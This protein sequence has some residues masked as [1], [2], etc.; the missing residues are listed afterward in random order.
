MRN[1]LLLFFFLIFTFVFG[2]AQHRGFLFSGNI[3]DSA[4]TIIKNAHILNLTSKKGT[5]SNDFGNY[6]IRAD[7]GDTLR[8]SSVQYETIFRVVKSHDLIS[9][10]INIQLK[11]KAYLLKEIVLKQHNLTGV[12]GIDLKKTP[13]DTVGEIVAR[14][15]RQ[16]NSFSLRDIME[17]PVQFNEMH[18]VKPGFARTDPTKL[19]RGAGIVTKLGSQNRKKSNRLQM[20]TKKFSAKKLIQ[21]I[22]ENY[23]LMLK[24]PREHHYAFIDFCRR[25]NLEELYEKNKMLELLKLLEEKSIVFLQKH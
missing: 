23:L 19:F 24:I 14:F 1:H 9:K 20:I 3:K 25:F 6:R 18:L 7:L 15:N 8:I 10:T 21:E 4:N 11:E 17:M 16:M 12:L 5:F 13:S 22:G 2:Q